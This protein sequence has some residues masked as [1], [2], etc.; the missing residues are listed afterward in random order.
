MQNQKKNAV[1]KKEC[2]SRE[3]LSGIFNAC[4]FRKHTETACVE[5]PRLL[6]SG[7]TTNFKEEALNKDAVRAPLRSGFTL[8]ELLVVVLIIGILAAVAVPQ[9][10]KA[11]LKSR[12]GQ[13]VL[14]QR[15]AR[16]ALD[17]YVLANGDADF[18]LDF[19]ENGKVTKL[20][21]DLTGGLSCSGTSCTDGIFSYQV[22]GDG[23]S[24]GTF[25]GSVVLY[26]TGNSG[27]G[28]AVDIYDEKQVDATRYDKACQYYSTEG[29][30][31]CELLHSLDNSYTAENYITD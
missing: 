19:I 22:Y 2:H 5:D 4:H 18:P 25:T 15:N 1:I 16:V 13:V 14:F 7:M 8:I 11:V 10:Q 28:A 30:R 29:K 23:G 20:D 17:A 9:Y 31:V 12:L 27:Y 26:G 3:L 6:P 24:D 21:I